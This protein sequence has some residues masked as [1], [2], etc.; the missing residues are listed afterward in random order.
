[1]K[2]DDDRKESHGEDKKDDDKKAEKKKRKELEASL[3]IGSLDPWER[4]RV[5]TDLLD[6]QNDISEMAD[7][8]TRFALVILGA[9]NAVNLFVVARPE[10]VLGD[11][12]A[13]AGWM[14][15]YLTTYIVLSLFIF[16]QSIGALRPRVGALMKKI[17][18]AG[19]N[20]EGMVGLRFTHTIVSTDFEAWYEKMKTSQFGDIN[21]DVAFSIRV[22]SEVVTDKY[23]KLDHM[24]AGLL[25][26][27]FLSAGLIFVLGLVRLL[28]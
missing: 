5:L 1:M 3:E 24:Y 15:A 16:V 25:V 17:G 21:R 11:K 6:V 13:G 20:T 14:G 9:V 27:V 4:Y 22:V 8:K 2:D 23:R 18:E 7:R 28:G 19:T 10:I 12:L 26:L